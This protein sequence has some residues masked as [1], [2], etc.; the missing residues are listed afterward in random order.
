MSETAVKKKKK[1]RS[2]V[3]K[4]IAL[5]IILAIIGLIAASVYRSLKK[6]YQVVYDAYTASIG[7]ISNALSFSGTLNLIDSKTYTAAADATV[8]GVYAEA[9]GL[10]WEFRYLMV[11][12]TVLNIVLNIL[13][14]RLWGVVGIISAT[15][16]SILFVNF[17]GSSHILFKYYFR[18]G[19]LREFFADH[20]K[21]LL[22]TVVITALTYAACRGAGTAIGGGKWGQLLVRGVV[23]AVLPAGLYVLAYGR[24]REFREAVSWAKQ[25][26][27][28]R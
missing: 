3:R 26:V 20:L 16:V 9:A 1:K 19:R 5:I 10:W 25:K 4:A 12:E 24:T 14:V 8:R 28:R 21:Y 11:A 27:F 6:E 23:C 17:F 18:N 15:I 22:V 7:T 2:P 13:F